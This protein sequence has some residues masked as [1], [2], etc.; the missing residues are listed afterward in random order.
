MPRWPRR[1]MTSWL[2]TAG[3]GKWSLSCTRHLVRLHLKSCA[4]FWDP[5]YTKGTEWLEAV[6]RRAK[7]LEKGLEQSLMKNSWGSCGCL[8][9]RSSSSGE[10]L[11]LSTTAWKQVA[12]RW[13]L[14]SSPRHLGQN[15]RRWPQAA[16]REV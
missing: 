1:S 10:T 12:A 5:H 9:W 8:A 11:Q 14:A 2:A 3:P 15:K 13:E 7:E 6:Q 4:Q 16:P